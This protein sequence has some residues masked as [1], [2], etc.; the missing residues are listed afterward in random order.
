MY[1]V[2]SRRGISLKVNI[3]TPCA[4]QASLSIFGWDMR[5]GFKSCALEPLL[6]GLCINM[7]HAVAS[8]LCRGIEA[9][10]TGLT[11]N[12]FVDNTTRGFESLPLRQRF[13]LT[14]SG[15]IEPFFFGT[16]EVDSHHATMSQGSHLSVAIGELAHQWRSDKSLPKANTPPL[17]TWQIQPFVV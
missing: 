10:I 2:A 1:I 5:S 11:R 9:V 6:S 16:E 12:Q 15:W 4:W 17:N 14:H 13:N 3:S 8:Y 7:M